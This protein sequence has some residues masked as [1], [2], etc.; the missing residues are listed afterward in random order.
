MRYAH[1]RPFLILPWTSPSPTG[2]PDAKVL[3]NK[4]A[5]IITYIILGVSY[6]NYSIVGPLII[7]APT[8][9]LRQSLDATR[10][11][12]TYWI[13]RGLLLSGMNDTAKGPTT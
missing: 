10:A 3:V 4:G 9:L 2:S 11:Q 7:Q 1:D 8:L 6:Y 5:L 13:V 12:D